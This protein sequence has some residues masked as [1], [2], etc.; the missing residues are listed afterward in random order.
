MTVT[1][2]QIKAW[3]DANPNASD[4]QVTQTMTANGVTAQQ[5]SD[6]TGIPI[7]KVLATEYAGTTLPVWA[8]KDQ[9]TYQAMTGLDPALM[10]Q[11]PKSLPT[12]TIQAP[13]MAGDVE[14]PTPTGNY[15]TVTQVDTSKLPAGVTPIYDS[16]DNLTG[17]S[18]EISTPTGWDSAVKLQANYDTNGNLLGYSGSNPI[19]PADTT[20]KLSKT[21]YDPIWSAT[22][23]ATPQQDTSTGGWALTA[24]I[25]QGLSMNPV[26]APFVAAGKVLYSL[27]NGQKIST[28][29][30]INAGIAAVGAMGGTPVDQI[31]NQDGSVTTTYS[32]GSSSTGMPTQGVAGA[33]LAQNLGD[34]KTGVNVY[35]AIQSKNATALIADL[36]KLAGV[37]SDYQVAFKA[38]NAIKALENGQPLT[39]ISP[40]ISSFMDS[41]D[42]NAVSMA[43]TMLST[44]QNNIKPTTAASTT[45]AVNVDSTTSDATPTVSPTTALPAETTPTTPATTPTTT[46]T[47]TL[48]TTPT[49][50][51]AKPVDP[52]ATPSIQNALAKIAVNQNPTGKI[53]AFDVN[54][55]F[56]AINSSNP[57]EDTTITARSGGSINDLVQLLNSR[58]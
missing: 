16:N 45:P 25:V 47:T 48:A 52:L 1:T 12:K 10:S 3:F 27:A 56:D 26:T 57:N 54:Q 21:K 20:G 33:T 23:Q 28:T 34:V 2:D 51:A 29:S 6:A 17:Y 37:S 24:P 53:K 40:Y 7:D 14:N 22:G 36:T 43:K 13:I 5:Y 55:I 46:P 50:V 39:A 49:A 38:A 31:P 15:Q 35:T 32:D 9:A 30:L 58:G 8:N 4:A 18:T 11:A 41:S 19:F 42:P 44:I